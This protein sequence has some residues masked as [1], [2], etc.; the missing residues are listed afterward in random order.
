MKTDN[1]YETRLP[2]SIAALTSENVRDEVK[3]IESLRVNNL[4]LIAAD[5]ERT[6]KFTVLK[7]SAFRLP[8]AHAL[9]YAVK[10]GRA[11]V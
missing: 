2:K 11:H 8:N 4:H 6:L 5:A 1:I 7:A 3:R 10:I 9:A